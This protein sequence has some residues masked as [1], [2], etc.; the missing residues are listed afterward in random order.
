MPTGAAGRR[1]ASPST[2]SSARRSRRWSAWTIARGRG[3]F[4]LVYV[5]AVRRPLAERRDGGRSGSARP[6]RRSRRA[7][8]AAHWYERE[9][10]DLLGLVPEGHPDPRRLVL[11]ERLAG[12]RLPAA[13]GLRPGDRPRPRVARAAALPS[14]ARRGHRRDPGRPDPRRRDRAGPLP[15]RGRRRGGAAPGGAALL[16]PSRHREGRRGEGVPI[17]ALQ[18]AERDLRRLRLSHA[19]A[20][21]Q[22]I[23]AIAGVDDSRRGR[24]RCARSSWSWS[25]CTTTSATSGNICAG[26]GF[27]VG[28]EPGL[29]AEG[30]APAAQRAPHRP[31]LPARR[32]R[33]RRRAARP[34]RRRAGA[35]SLTTLDG[36]E[37]SSAASS[38]CSRSTDPFQERLH[39][40]RRRCRRVAAAV[41]AR[42][43]WRRGPAGVD[44]DARRDHPHA[45]TPDLLSPVPV[46]HDGDVRA[47]AQV[48]IDEA[49]DVVRLVRSAARRRCRTGP[50]ARRSGRCPPT[51]VG[52][53]RD[54]VAARRERPLGPDRARRHDRP[55]PHPLGVVLQLADRRR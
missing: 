37:P 32:L 30:G 33:A 3:A 8:P 29:A 21:C 41:S 24:R 46:Q 47:R 36:V 34:R 1:P 7:C 6:S 45:A 2:S 16:H 42:S 49:C 43:A 48:R 26:V 12:R 5:F 55:L 35:T 19:V 53:R 28:D 13:Q 50:L 44:R 52:A 10:Q 23:E 51:G 38:I 20:Y 15:L 54:R 18:I 39:R 25:G 14:A 9:V 27:A 40:D 11:H 17:T 31:P 4:R 22:A